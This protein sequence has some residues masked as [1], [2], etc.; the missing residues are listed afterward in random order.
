MPLP[1][2]AVFA[3]GAIGGTATAKGT[4]ALRGW[5]NEGESITCRCRRCG[6]T[7]PHVFKTIDRSWAGGAVIGAAV[8]AIGGTVAGVVA[9]RIFACRRCD[10]VMYEDGTPPDWNADDAI[11]QALN[12]NDVRE[13]YSQLQMLCASHQHLAQRHAARIRELE[14]ELASGRADREVLTAKFQRLVAQMRT[15][16]A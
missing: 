15:E 4:A 9:K 3:L 7:G 1:L 14:A 2:L 5:L 10:A 8:G 16:A 11:D 6:N 13:A 12:Y